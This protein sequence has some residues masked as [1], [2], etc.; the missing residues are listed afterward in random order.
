MLSRPAHDLDVM[1]PLLHNREPLHLVVASTGLNMDVT[2]KKVQ[3]RP[4][5]RSSRIRRMA[6]NI[7]CR[8]PFAML[9]KLAG[10]LQPLQE[11]ACLNRR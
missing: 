8:A 6:K 3:R 1:L 10:F 9:E 7:V 4:K 5:R 2:S 11:V